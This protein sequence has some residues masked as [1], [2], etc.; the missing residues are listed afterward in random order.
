MR[1]TIII[2]EK[3]V[4]FRATASTLKRYM[5]LTGRDLIKDFEVIDHEMKTTTSVSSTDVLMMF[6][7]FAYVMAK[8]ADSRIPDD[9]DEWLDTFD[10][11]PID[12]VMPQLV[13]LWKQ[14]VLGKVE[15]KKNPDQQSE[16]S[17]QP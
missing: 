17:V 11:F 3:P 6:F 5:D 10:V 4:A 8:Q 14:S 9:P 15:L 16:K 2:D 7:N 1:K 12:E 13:N